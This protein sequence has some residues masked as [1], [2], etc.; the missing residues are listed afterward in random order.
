MWVITT[1]T[2][3]LTPVKMVKTNETNDSSRLRGYRVR[4]PLIHCSFECKHVEPLW[5]SLWHF[6]SHLG[7]YLPQAPATSVLGIHRKNS[8]F[9]YRDTC[10]P[11]FTTALFTIA[12]NWKQTR[13][14]SVDEWI[15]NTWYIY[16]MKY[17]LALKKWNHA[18]LRLMDRRNILKKYLEWDNTDLERQ[19]WHVFTYTE[20]LALKSSICRPQSTQP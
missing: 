20:M 12:R 17:Y 19:I 14:P 13:C 15:K 11:M 6:L 16:T 8:T 18:I 3:N 2:F 1:V 5:R 7:R 10:S 9:S 4:G